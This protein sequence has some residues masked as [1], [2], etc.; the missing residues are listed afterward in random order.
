MLKLGDRVPHYGELKQIVFPEHPQAGELLYFFVDR[1]GVVSLMPAV[2]ID[3]M[4]R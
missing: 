2:I 1:H 3:G 4:T